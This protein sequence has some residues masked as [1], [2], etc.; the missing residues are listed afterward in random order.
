MTETPIPN[1]ALLV[2]DMQEAFLQAIPQADSLLHRCSFAVEAAAL[3]GMRT[4]FTTQVPEKLG[5]VVPKLLGLLAEPAVFP[6]TGFSALSAPNL[7]DTLSHNE[8]DHLILAGVEIPIC[9]YQTVIEATHQEMAMT[10]LSDCI[11]GR[12]EADQPP[13]LAALAQVGCHILPSEAIFYSILGRAEHPK[14]REFTSLVKK[15]HTTAS[16]AP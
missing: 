2:V 11:G 1:V 14:F 3:L 13:V 15:Y 5:P 8:I 4:F 10:L 6:K 16:P 7:L 9:I 12:R